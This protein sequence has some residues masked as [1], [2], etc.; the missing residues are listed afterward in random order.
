M[1]PPKTLRP[2][3]C[4]ACWMGTRRWATVISTEPAITTTKPAMMNKHGWTAVFFIVVEIALVA[5]PSFVY[6][7]HQTHGLPIPAP[8]VF[9]MA[10]SFA[11]ATA[12]SILT[13]RVAMARGIRAL[14]TLGD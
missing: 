6:L 3:V 8:R 5:Y 12:L 4:L 9:P 10:V 14:Q 13:C 11:A 7:W 1:P 2:R